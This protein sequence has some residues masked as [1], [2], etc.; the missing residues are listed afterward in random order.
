LADSIIAYAKNENIIS[1]PSLRKMIDGEVDIFAEVSQK[2][3]R[4]RDAL[5]LDNSQQVERLLQP[6]ETKSWGRDI[7][8]DYVNRKKSGISSPLRTDVSPGQRDLL[9]TAN[10]K[11]ANMDTKLRSDMSKIK[12]NEQ[13]QKL[14][15][16]SNFSKM[17]NQQALAHLVVGPIGTDNADTIKKVLESSIMSS[18]YEGR[19]K[20]DIFET[21]VG[22]YFFRDYSV[23]NRD[24]QQILN[25]IID[26]IVTKIQ[27]SPSELWKEI[28]NAIDA[29]QSISKDA[30]YLARPQSI[31]KITRIKEKA[32][33]AEIQIGAFYR[34]EAERIANETMLDLVS[35]P[36]KKA[37]VDISKNISED[38]KYALDYIKSI[39]NN[40]V[41][42]IVAHRI[43]QNAQGNTILDMYNTA[44]SDIADK[45]LPKNIADSLKGSGYNKTFSNSIAEI[46]LEA[47]DLAK[48]IAKANDLVQGVNPDRIAQATARFFED[49]TI[50]KQAEL[51]FGK[52]VY[53]SIKKEIG[54]GGNKI[55]KN[56]R[57]LMSM[58]YD[59][60]DWGTLEKTAKGILDTLETV[61]YTAVLT[62]ATR[63][64]GGNIF[65]APSV[66]INSLGKTG[67]ASLQ[68]VPSAIRILTKPESAANTIAFT[69]KAGRSYTIA[70]VR[71]A[72]NVLGGKSVYSSFQPN[73]VTEEAI[74]LA[75]DNPGKI[76]NVP[77]F[78]S[79]L[80]SFAQK[81]DLTFRTAV[82][83]KALKDGRN[84][85]EALKLA[86]A[87]MYDVGDI[88]ELERQSNRFFLFYNF[89]RNN[90]VATA[91]NLLSL[92]GLNRLYKYTKAKKSI[93]GALGNEQSE[94]AYLPESAQ[95]RLVLDVFSKGGDNY[96]VL[97][98]TDA[99]MSGLS[100]ITK[101]AEGRYLETIGQMLTPGIKKTFD[102]SE[103]PE[104]TKVPPEHL[105]FLPQGFID[106][107]AGEKVIPELAAPGDS[108]AI[109]GYIYPLKSER[110]QRRYNDF[111]STM[112]YFGISRLMTDFPR[113]FGAKGTPVDAARSGKLAYAFAMMSPMKVL[114]KEKTTLYNT[115]AQ[116]AEGRKMLK[117][118]EKIQKEA[119]PIQ[120]ETYKDIVSKNEI[121]AGLE[122]KTTTLSRLPS[123]EKQIMAYGQQAKAIIKSRIMAGTIGEDQIDAEA[124]KI[125]ENISRLEGLQG[126]EFE[127]EIE[128]L[129]KKNK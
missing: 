29:A 89:N 38:A 3:V 91:K 84:M 129:I 67:L 1:L 96:A 88:T 60:N 13:F 24:G 26:D 79:F 95:E 78:A 42:N 119:A 125:E 103:M 7:V 93:E 48:T 28:D 115:I 120:A 36:I 77:K 76:D 32:L 104:K 83:I 70:E 63:F 127:Q 19:A 105:A 128:K 121:K 37:G 44:A 53:N 109:D 123:K 5:L 124:A 2:A 30:S 112:E 73:M 86:R 10:Q 107:M 110:A 64:H 81:E 126:S 14:Y 55:S 94:T 65:G 100:F 47:D 49:P 8:L 22:A 25:A 40:A 80:N 62:L 6:L 54:Q 31:N 50:Q 72:A 16:N 15:T 33:P 92:E 52:D 68:E 20:E 4:A 41:G 74:R 61:F 101:I 114:S 97:G 9:R 117:E 90:I 106:T 12:N 108:T 51:L 116:T 43:K 18:I 35:G 23:F 58:K 56:L 118:I 82:L 34:A 46:V 27:K 99:I 57:D 122:E 69:D 11:A 39:D 66:L 111:I 45:F 85:D 59:A 21:L 75:K 17:T 102:I 98:P 87:S 71:D 113:M